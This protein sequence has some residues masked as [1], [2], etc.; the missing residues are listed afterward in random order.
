ME[1]KL[2]YDMILSM[3][4][5]K[6]QSKFFSAF[7]ILVF[8][9][10]GVIWLTEDLSK[11][12]DLRSNPEVVE[13]R[14]GSGAIS[15]EIAT[16]LESRIRGLSGR[17]LLLE[18]FGLLFIFPE[19]DFHGIWMKEMKFPIDIIWLNREKQIVDLA[20][21]VPPDSYP[22]VFY[23]REKALFVLEIL[24]GTAQKIGIKVGDFARFPI[25]QPF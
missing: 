14:F 2:I 11:G 17:E 8:L 7:I 3:I 20:I 9:G 18:N 12:S 4:R 13:I 23:P 21:D 6:H 24:A 25:P 22:Q 19:S 1:H 10:W 16:D 15:A 5:L